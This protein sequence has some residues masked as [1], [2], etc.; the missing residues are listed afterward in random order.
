MVESC[1]CPTICGMAGATIGPK[2]TLVNILYLMTGSTLGWCPLEDL[3]DVT[4]CTTDNY[5]LSIQFEGR[6]IVIEGS[7]GPAVG[8]VAGPAIRAKPP[9]MDIFGRMAG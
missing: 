1:R 9:P 4:I 7:R 3:V 8:G 5:V 2:S 6:Q